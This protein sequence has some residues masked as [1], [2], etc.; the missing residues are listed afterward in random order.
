MATAMT[1]PF[2]IVYTQRLVSD[3]DNRL[4]EARPD[5]YFQ[6]GYSAI[7]TGWLR[8][9]QRRWSDLGVLIGLGLHARP[10]LGDDFKL[11][12]KLG[13]VGPADEGRLYAR[14]TDLGLSEVTGID[15]GI[16]VP[17]CAKRL[18]EDQLLRILDLPDDFRDSHGQFEGRHAYLMLGSVTSQAF[19][20][21][22]LPHTVT[23]HRVGLP[24]TVD[25]H[26]DPHRVGLPHTKN[27]TTS[28]T[29]ADAGG[30]ESAPAGFESAAETDS[31]LDDEH[32]ADQSTLVLSGNGHGA[33]RAEAAAETDA[34]AHRSQRDI[35]RR[36]NTA[37]G[38][39]KIVAA[40]QAV[41]EVVESQ[42]GFTEAGLRVARLAFAPLPDRRRRVLDDLRRMQGRT[43]LK[44]SIRK[45][46]MIGILTQNIGLTL[47]L[48]LAANG[49]LRTLADRADYTA[50]GG[51]VADYG[52]EAVWLAA[53][54]IAGQRFEGDPIEYLRAALRNKREREHGKGEPVSRSFDNVDYLSEQV[55]IG[56]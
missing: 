20:R 24:H 36:L 14:V 53:C 27:I 33:H 28:L 46:N 39:E 12:S 23:S 3:A 1:N 54:E 48:G 49:S 55:G 13:L 32:A 43:D 35:W 34:G 18:A 15:R 9:F 51:L 7:Q 19:D 42:L 38:D 31:A 37:L 52:S 47:G 5:I 6:I 17:T 44:A 22:G 11:L 2:Q 29:P 30:A 16:G 45:R 40:F 4:T 56:A 8:K 10:L 50:I 41:L 21:V 26:N 25:G